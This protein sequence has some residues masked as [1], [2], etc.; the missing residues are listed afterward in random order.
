[1]IP[2]F[3]LL[4]VFSTF[5]RAD[6]PDDL[7]VRCC[8]RV[9]ICGETLEDADCGTNPDGSSIPY[10]CERVHQ[11]PICPNNGLIK[12]TCNRG[13]PACEF[14]DEDDDDE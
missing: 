4:A 6:D 10:T 8:D 9:N 12:Q 7:V 2:C 13:Q 1:V 14:P 11:Y 3:M 5:N